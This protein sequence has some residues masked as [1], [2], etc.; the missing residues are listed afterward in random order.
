[1][2]D[3]LKDSECPSVIEIVTRQMVHSGTYK[4]LILIQIS[5]SKSKILLIDNNELKHFPE[6]DLGIGAESLW[7]GQVRM[8]YLIKEEC[9]VRSKSATKTVSV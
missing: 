6:T 9:A 8:K 4:T 1:M 5:N 7:I 2:K 3:F